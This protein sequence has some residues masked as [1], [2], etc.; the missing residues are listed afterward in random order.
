MNK[1]FWFSGWNLIPQMMYYIFRN[2]FFPI[3]LCH[4]RSKIFHFHLLM[5]CFC[6]LYICFVFPN[7]VMKRLSRIAFKGWSALGQCQNYTL[8]GC[9]W[10]I[11]KRR[12]R[13]GIFHKLCSSSISLSLH[14]ISQTPV[15]QGSRVVNPWGLR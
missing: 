2:L 8:L 14:S 3:K 12:G 4:G 11:F 13:R 15:T 7:R 9:L 6:L 10:I 1:L 5:A